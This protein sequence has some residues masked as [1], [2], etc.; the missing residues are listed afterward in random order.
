MKKT[1]NNSD[2]GQ[3]KPTDKRTSREAVEN[4]IDAS[5]SM[6]RKK[7]EDSDGASEQV[8]R[9]SYRTKSSGSK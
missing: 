9:W 7:W 3:L 8:S 6:N 5:K 4:A 2:K 1:A